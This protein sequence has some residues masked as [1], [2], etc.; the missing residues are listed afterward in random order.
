M[1]KNTENFKTIA[2]LTNEKEQEVLGGDFR[3]I[4]PLPQIVFF[5]KSK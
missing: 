4:R 1:F 2:H 3:K 5:S